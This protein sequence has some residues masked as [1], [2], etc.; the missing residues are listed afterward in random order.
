MPDRTATDGGVSADSRD[1]VVVC[2]GAGGI[3]RACAAWFAERYP[4]V[5]LVDVDADAVGAAAD[6]VGARAI[7]ADLTDPSAVRVAFDE[8]ASFA[9]TAVLVN[10]TGAV[11]SGAVEDIGLDDWNRVLTVN[12]TSAFLC[13]QAAIPQLRDGSWGK[14]VN[15]SSVNARTGGNDLSGAAY[16]VAKAGIGALTRHLA[17]S[18]APAVQVNAVAPGPVRTPMLDRLTDVELDGL[19]AALPAGRIAEPEEIAAAVGFLASREAD[20]VTGVTLDQ[21]GGGW[22]G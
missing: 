11:G 19:V 16:A 3:G 12:L 7:V 17:R 15:L 10:A 21:N 6:A 8:I 20:Y 22:I 2:G 5:V 14:V 13:A 9:R 1:A 18:L 4:T